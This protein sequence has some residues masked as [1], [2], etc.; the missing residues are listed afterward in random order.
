[1]KERLETTDAARGRPQAVAELRGVHKRYGQVDALQGV[2]LELRPGELVAPL[3]PNGAGKTTAVSILL[4]QAGQQ[5]GT[6]SGGA[7]RVRQT[8]G[9]GGLGGGGGAIGRPVAIIA[10]GPDGVR[11]KPVV[12]L[13]KVALAGLTTWATMLGLLRARRKARNR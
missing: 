9:A 7:A 1:V 11:I 2:D 4:G 5:G 13:T 8:G 6:H 3:G 10:I 12:D